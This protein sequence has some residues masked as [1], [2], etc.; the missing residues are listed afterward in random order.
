[1]NAKAD[2][3]PGASRTFSVDTR[4]QKMARRA[5]GIPREKAIEQ[6]EAGIEE[7]MPEFGNWLEMQIRQLDQIVQAAAAGREQ[8]TW[9]TL[10]E[11]YA[12]QLRDVGTTMGFQLVTVIADALAKILAG[13]QAGAELHMNLILCHVDALVVVRQEQFRGL[14]PA[15]VPELVGGLRRAM[16]RVYPNGLPEAEA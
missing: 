2:Q 10:A 9:I 15:D 12:G 14:G 6:A 1:M 5:G 11:Y 7:V 16:A 8:P 3:T 4:F 13:V